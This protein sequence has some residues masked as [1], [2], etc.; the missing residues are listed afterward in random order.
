M[1]TA[2]S[3]PGNRH[4]FGR[5]LD[6]EYAYREEV[7][8]T[9]RNYPFVFRCGA[10]L[11]NHYAMIGMATISEG[12][13]LYYDATNEQGLSIAALNF[14]GNAKYLP[15]TSNFDNIAPFELIPWVLGQCKSTEDAQK[16]LTQVNVWHLPFSR[17]FPLSPLHW[18]ISDK[19]E[20]IVV[21]PM[22]NGLQIYKNPV[23]ILTNSPPFPYHLLHLADYAGLR[24]E[25]SANLFQEYG[26]QRYSNGMGALGLPGDFSS[27]SRFVKAAF[28]TQNS[29]LDGSEVNQFFHLLAC[30]AMPSG[31]IRIDGKNEITRY[32]S[33]CDTESGIYYYTTYENCRITAIE[34]QKCPLDGSNLIPYP[35]RDRLDIR[36][37]N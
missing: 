33:C 15:K 8:V 23:G 36:F 9:P 20:S 28:V 32:S 37:E 16:L 25:E 10:A 30:V 17:K 18:I 5:N 3:Y 27:S 26:I 12:Y 24:A 13:P 31:S 4:Y 19:Q 34:M 29:I 21:E 2:L 14:P 1:C 7:V 22:N 35:L 6:L 11:Q